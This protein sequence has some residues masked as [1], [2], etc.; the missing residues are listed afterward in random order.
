MNVEMEKTLQSQSM[1][2]TKCSIKCLPS[3]SFADRVSFLRDIH[4]NR[5]SRKMSY[6]FVSIAQIESHSFKSTFKNT[7]TL[8]AQRTK[9]ETR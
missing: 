7:N 5:I 9:L 4:Q 8:T 2:M 1:S 6:P 3:F